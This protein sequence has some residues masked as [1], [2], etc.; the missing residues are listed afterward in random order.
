MTSK[1]FVTRTVLLVVILAAC[2]AACNAYV[3]VFGL[4]R[5]THG[6]RIKVYYQERMS[7]YLL[8]HRYIPENFDS[9]LIGSSASDNFDTSTFQSVTMYNLSL[10]GANATELRLIAEEAFRR[11][12]FKVVIFCLNEYLVNTAGRK[13]SYIHP[14][15]YWSALGSPQLLMTYFSQWLIDRGR[16]PDLYGAD[17]VFRFNQREIPADSS[18]VQIDAEVE[19]IKSGESAHKFTVNQ[20]GLEDLKLLA[21]EAEMHAD[22]VIGFFMPMPESIR[23][24]TKNER[25]DFAQKVRASFSSRIQILDFNNDSSFEDFRADFDNY[26]DA[27]HLSERGATTLMNS[28][29]KTL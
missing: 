6:R 25:E 14:Q 7:K 18:K 3:D 5:D 9:L 15:D 27:S 21:S 29:A 16:K 4:F 12:H 23:Q 17:G 10:D 28:L 22:K 19:R 26:R 11:R 2:F 24:V 20:E 8:A 1:Q 13:T